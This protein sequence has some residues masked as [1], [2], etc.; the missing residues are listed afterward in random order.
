VRELREKLRIL[1]VYGDRATL[2]ATLPEAA[3][4]RR[5]FQQAEVAFVAVS[6]DGSKR[7]EWGEPAA[8]RGGWLWEAAS[9]AEWRAYMDSIL[10]EKT[11]AAE[12]VGRS[13]SPRCDTAQSARNRLASLR[14]TGKAESMMHRMVECQYKSPCKRSVRPASGRLTSLCGAG[15]VAGHEQE[16]PLARVRAGRARVR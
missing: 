10:A 13:A 8:V 11:G 9:P 12:Q 14:F 2:R 6:S 3:A 4:F 7:S 16:G 1:V 5:R 15:R